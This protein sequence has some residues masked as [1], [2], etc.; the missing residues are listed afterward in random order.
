MKDV[1]LNKYTINDVVDGLIKEL[2]DNPNLIVS[3]Q[4]AKQ[5]KWGMARLWYMWMKATADHMAKSGVTM[6]MMV[7]KDGGNYLTREFDEKDAHQLFT[8]QYL[9]CDES[10]NRLSWSRSGKDGRRAATKGE[11]FIAMLKHEHWC[12]ERGIVL[13]NPREGEYFKLFEEQNK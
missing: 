12:A 4:N 1:H 13:M 8:H 2:E 6:P 10:G 9:G 5:A 11:R 7:K 3:T